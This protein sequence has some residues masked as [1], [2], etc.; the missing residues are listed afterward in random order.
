MAE[1]KSPIPFEELSPAQKAIWKIL[2]PVQT[3]QTRGIEYEFVFDTENN[4]YQL[5]ANGWQNGKRIHH[6]MLHFAI[7]G[8]YVWIEENTTEMEFLE[9]FL[10]YGIGKDQIVLGFYPPAHRVVEGFAAGA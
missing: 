4:Q 2:E 3:W 6:V 9:T 10:E 1:L 8:Q 5:L 7:R